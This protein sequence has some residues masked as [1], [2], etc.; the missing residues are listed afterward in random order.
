MD[1]N[2]RMALE[3][4]KTTMNKCVAENNVETLNVKLMHSYELLHQC[5]KTGQVP[6]K[7]I[8]ELMDSDEVFKKWL[9][10]R[11]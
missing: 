7:E 8:Q 9:T 4:G 6:E 3:I 10:A 1:I 5:I 11:G 2:D